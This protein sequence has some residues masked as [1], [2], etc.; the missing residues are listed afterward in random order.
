[1]LTAD[2]IIEA[3][4]RTNIEVVLALETLQQD[5]RNRIKKADSDI[6]ILREEIRQIEKRIAMYEQD[7]LF[8]HYSLKI[9]VARVAL[10]E[11]E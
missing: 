9:L 6:P 8:S 4:N 5:R 3:E 1:M 7:R 10:L 11:E 2:V